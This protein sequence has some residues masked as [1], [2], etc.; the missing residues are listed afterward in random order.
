MGRKL[1]KG[2]AHLGVGAGFPSNTMWPGPRP[3]SVTSGI[4]IHP[5]V[6][7]QQICAENWGLLRLFW[8]SGSWIPIQQNIPRPRPTS[9]PSGVLIHSI[10]PFGHNTWAERWGLLCHL[11]VG[12]GSPSE[13]MWPGPRPISMTSFILIHSTVWPQYT[14]TNRTDRQTDRQDRADNGPIA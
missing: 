5:A 8:G 11:L 13:T 12:S 7:P 3:T 14:V 6:W 4:L 2:C 9:V 10:Q 1:G